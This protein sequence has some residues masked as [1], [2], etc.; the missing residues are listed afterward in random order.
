MA[1]ARH[2]FGQDDLT[3]IDLDLVTPGKFDLSSTTEHHDV[4]SARCARGWAATRCPIHIATRLPTNAARISLPNLMVVSCQNIAAEFF[5]RE[6]W[7][8]LNHL[9]DD[10]A[11]VAA[12]ARILTTFDAVVSSQ[13]SEQPVERSL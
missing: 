11:F 3:G 6:R 7:L 13:R 9:A 5:I 4:L 10:D 1:F 2:V 8:S 12:K